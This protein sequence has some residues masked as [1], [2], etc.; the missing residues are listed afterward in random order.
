VLTEF[1]QFVLRGSLVDLSVAVVVGTAF[2]AVVNSL[3]SN[4]VT[5][6]IAAVF[7]NPDFSRLHFT[8]NH[9]TFQY[10]TFINAVFTFLIVAA[11]LFFLVIK[12]MNALQH[13]GPTPTPTARECPE[14]LSMIPNAAKRCSHC[15]SQVTPVT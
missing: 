7:G 8:L 13:L 15:T 3:V 4:I 1:K 9:S 14:C 5:P 6:L 10:G 11:V 2:T 12:P